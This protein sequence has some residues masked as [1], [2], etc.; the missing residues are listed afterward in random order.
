[1]PR[2]LPLILQIMDRLNVGKPVSSTYLDLFCRCY[3]E[4]F[5]RLDKVH[6]M[7][8]SAGF[9][10]K[11]DITPRRNGWKTTSDII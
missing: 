5:V 2:T 9:I 4:S 10:T 11:R 6:E 8:F 1:V 3:D 7:A